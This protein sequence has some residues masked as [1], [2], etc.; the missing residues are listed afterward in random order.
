MWG[1]ASHLKKIGIVLE[2]LTI[3]IIAAML[4]VP[5]LL[6]LNTYRDLITEKIE[7][8]I[9]GKV[10]I[11]VIRWGFTDG[12]WVEINDFSVLGD[13]VFRKN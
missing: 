6:D 2:A 7:K 12:I 5:K 3:V 11:G 13:E 10:A 4:I 1:K 9:G 8:T